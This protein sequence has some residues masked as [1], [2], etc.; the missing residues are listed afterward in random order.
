MDD[1][2]KPILRA[3]TSSVGTALRERRSIRAF[4]QTPVPEDMLEDILASALN[5]PSWGNV[6]P[7][8]V[9]IA[10][11]GTAKIISTELLEKFETANAFRKASLLQ[12]LSMLV[13][14]G[15]R[16]D[17]DFNTI[18]TYPKEL[19]DRYRETGMGLYGVLGIKRS[20]RQARH[21]QMA[22]NFQFFDAPTVLFVFSES[23]LGAYG[24]LDTGAFIQSLALAA[25]E[26]GLGTCIQ[27][28][29]AT[30]ASPVRAHFD[31]PENYK[32]IC[33]ISI[34]YPTDDKVNSFAPVRRSLQEL[35]VKQRK[36]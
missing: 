4:E 25:H 34:G 32:L 14:G 11:G 1:A 2:T 36:D 15:F 20:D 8:R 12:K 10:T 18:M 31:V 33:G 5:A 28:A 3:S 22:R 23:S 6:Q 7:Y 9:A 13:K 24:P 26:K 16:P 17:G 21:E 27:A 29:L 30:W 35:I 19:G